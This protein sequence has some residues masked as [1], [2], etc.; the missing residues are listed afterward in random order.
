MEVT[1]A[2][3]TFGASVLGAVVGA[4]IAFYGARS[5]SRRLAEANDREQRRAEKA[6]LRAAVLELD[7]ADRIA[8]A[9]S[10]TDLPMQMLTTVLP[11]VH[12]M[13]PEQQ[14]VMVAYSQS[15]LRYN[16]RVRRIVAY[17]A[18]K[19]TRGMRP[20]AEK[21]VEH[22]AVVRDA[23]PAAREALREHMASPRYPDDGPVE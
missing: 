12:H 3:T 18:A 19:R 16:G 21:P 6:A 15:V 5:A 22:A 10:T 4:L 8:K 7:V 17:G 11:V 23:A 9:E 20:G 13:R 2:V 14:Q 1:E